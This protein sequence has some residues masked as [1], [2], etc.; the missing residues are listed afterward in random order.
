MADFRNP[1]P[2]GSTCGSEAGSLY[3]G[4]SGKKGPTPLTE[5]SKEDLIQRCK[6]LL[7]I[8]QKAKASK[9]G[10]TIKDPLVAVLLFI[11][12]SFRSNDPHYEIML[13]KTSF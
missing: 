13:L 5:L 11:S 7:Q 12:C 6:K 8:A 2:P 3:E 10:K 4:S 9:D 1:S